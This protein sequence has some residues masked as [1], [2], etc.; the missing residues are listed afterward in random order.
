MRTDPTIV[1]DPST[2]DCMNMGDV[3][4]LQGAVGNLRALWPSARIHVL[5][6]APSALS[7]HCPS[8]S[9][10]SHEGRRLW[11]SDQALLGNVDR[12]APRG[13]A[14]MKRQLGKRLRRRWPKLLDG[15]QRTKA[16]LRHRG[17]RRRQNFL[18][19]MKQVDLYFVSGAALLNDKGTSEAMV[20]LQTMEM[21]T[22]RGVPA[23]MVSQGIGPLSNPDL[24]GR[25]RSVLPSADLIA[26]REGLTGKDLLQKL[27]VSAERVMIAGDDAIEIA[28]AD[29][30]RR[31]GS[32][33]GVNLR[34]ARSTDI[35][36]GFVPTIRSALQEAAR[37]FAVPLI[38]IP[39]AFHSAANDPNTI[40][41]LLA[42]YDDDSDGGQRLA[43]PRDVIEQAGR[44]RIVVTSAYHAAVF[45]LAQ[46]IPAV[47]LINNEYY[48]LKF[49]GL[50]DL[51]GGG[52]ELIDLRSPTLRGDL[53]TAIERTW[54][55]AE[56]WR[57][58]LR[59]AADRQ[60]E[61][62]AAVYQRVYQL[63]G[64]ERRSTQAAAP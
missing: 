46:G 8:V 59:Q 35:G 39:I 15:L 2:L 26:L 4:M 34:V 30:S 29:P 36:A 27:G 16:R 3:A 9:A 47:A 10:L 48:E 51:F 12:Y 33:I 1:V 60:V 55:G 37:R 45:A 7:F 28:R 38:P 24:I 43:T 57:F 58:K 19:Q 13:V 50:R 32:G 18:E 64:A 6:N 14:S 62:I 44:C 22:R 56:E 53:S 40:R 20:V 17:D 61:R 11:F 42:G 52:C 23:V 31:S 5:T 21:A 49:Q 41:E 63:V 54:S 25:A